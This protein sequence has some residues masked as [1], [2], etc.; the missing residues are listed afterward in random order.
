MTSR[1]LEYVTPPNNDGSN[2]S[3]SSTAS[4]QSKM[5]N[6][7]VQYAMNFANDS[8]HTSLCLQF[9]AKRIA[10][11]CVYMS[12]QY[13]K[14]RPSQKDRQSWLEL[15]DNIEMNN[16]AS[17]CLQIME[18]IAGKKGCDLPIFKTI[19]SDLQKMKSQ[20]SSSSSAPSSKRQRV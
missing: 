5:T 20:F 6:E 14:M 11:A 7:L 3:S 17:I 9:P 19:R 13:C 12:A 18:L 16:L 1:Q 10:Q 4:L 2:A 8:M 15:L